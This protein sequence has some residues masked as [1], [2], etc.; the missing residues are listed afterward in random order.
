M[1]KRM[2]KATSLLIAA[3]AVVSL[4]PATGASAATTQLATK[5]GTINKAIAFS[6]GNYLYEGYKNDNDNDGLYYNSGNQDKSLDSVSN[7]DIEGTYADKY[8]YALDGSDQYLVDLSN[9][10]VSDD[11]TPEDDADTAATKLKTALKKTDRYGSSITVDSSNLGYNSSTDTGVLAGNKFGA[12]WYEY[13]VATTANDAASNTVDG[14]LYGFTNGNGQYIDASHVANI[15]AYST[16]KGKM[17]KLDEFSN[18][19]DDVDSDSGLLATL[20]KAP[21]VLTQDKDYIYALVTVNVT[22]T[23]SNAIMAGTTTGAAVTGLEGKTV[24]QRTYVQKISKAQGDQVDGAYVPKTVDSYEILGANDQLDSGDAKDAGAAITNALE[25]GKVTVS[26]SQLLAVEVTS[27]NV[28]VTSID[29]KKDKL[30]YLKVNGTQVNASKVDAYVAEKNDSDDIDV[31]ADYSSDAY[32]VDVNGNVWVVADGKISEFKD[33]KFA[34]VYST[35][36]S[37]DA[38]SVYDAN[39]IIAWKENGD[40]YTTVAGTDTTTPPPTGTAGWVKNADG[41]WSYN[42]ADGTKSTGWVQD[43]A[44]YFLNANGIMQTGWVNDNGTWYFLSG[45]G[46]MKTGWV[47]DNGTWYYLKSS[48]AMATGWVNDNG[49]WYY[50][51]SSGAMATGWVNDNGTWYYLNASGAMLANTTVD[52]YVLGASGAWIK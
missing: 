31:N 39:N 52:G 29:L 8:A 15:Y 48:G 27:G 40:I 35:D 28:K 2:S 7:A 3:A 36:S 50:L 1:I 32:D 13:N 6:N 18:S 25:N 11:Q 4:M 42:K 44:W 22:D 21:Q 51:K 46:A 38:I 45:S 20:A 37:L 33:N 47:N 12:S 14:K 43:G 5:D 30:N 16:A 26:G 34:D 23:D 41:T 19:K 10:N 17:V 24:T 49:T 9:G